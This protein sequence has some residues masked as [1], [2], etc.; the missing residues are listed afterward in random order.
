[1]PLSELEAVMLKA[2]NSSYGDAVD[3]YIEENPK[4]VSYWVTGEFK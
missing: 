1:M 4:R 3:A 2:S